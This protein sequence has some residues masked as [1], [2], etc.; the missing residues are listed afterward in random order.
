MESLYFCKKVKFGDSIGVVDVETGEILFD[1]N[2]I[3][4]GSSGEA[5]VQFLR[6]DGK[7]FVHKVLKLT[8]K[9]NNNKKS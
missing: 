3:H 9:Q 2:L 1:K 4:F 8:T 6:R 5:F 7:I